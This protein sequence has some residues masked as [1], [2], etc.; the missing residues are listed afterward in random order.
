M[1]IEQ[2]FVSAIPCAFLSYFS[3]AS[4]VAQCFVSLMDF[5]AF[6]LLEGRERV[7]W[8]MKLP[9][10]ILPQ[11]LHKWVSKQLPNFMHLSES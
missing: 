3:Q 1:K 6:D 11:N 10:N 4:P 9:L 2:P 5:L 8:G 7:V